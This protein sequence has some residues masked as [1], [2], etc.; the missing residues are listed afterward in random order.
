MVE[1]V[2]VAC[3]RLDFVPNYAG[4]T[5]EGWQ[6][7]ISTMIVLPSEQNSAIVDYLA[8]NFPAKPGT[9]PVIVAGFGQCHHQRMDC[10]DV[11]VAAA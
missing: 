10:P 1:G 8:T 5:H 9:A 2:C 7:L 4:N 11:G 6:D 3:H